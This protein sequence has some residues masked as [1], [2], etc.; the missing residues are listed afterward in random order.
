M[1]S[2][3]GSDSGVRNREWFGGF[4][5]CEPAGEVAGGRTGGLPLWSLNLTMRR[6][7]SIVRWRPGI[8][9]NIFCRC[10]LIPRS[11]SN[12]IPCRIIFRTSCIRCLPGSIRTTRTTSSSTAASARKWNHHSPG[13]PP[14]TVPPD[15]QPHPQQPAQKTACGFPQKKQLDTD[16]LHLRLPDLMRGSI[17]KR[18]DPDL[19]GLRIVFNLIQQSRNIL[20]I[21]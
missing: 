4:C 6:L 7:W 19:P 15:P 3:G 17:G 10:I 9:G 11:I 12:F 2:A 8:P 5:G 21:P 20:V 14:Q 16:Q 18:M 1:M 13:K